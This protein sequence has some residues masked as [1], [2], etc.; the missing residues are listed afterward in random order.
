MNENNLYQSAFQEQHYSHECLAS[1]FSFFHSLQRTLKK[2]VSQ[3]CTYHSIQRLT[4][5]KDQIYGRQKPGARHVEALNNSSHYIM[6]EKGSCRSNLQTWC[7]A[8]IFHFILE[9][10][11]Q[12]EFLWIEV[13]SAHLP[14]F[15]SQVYRKYQLF[16]SL[17]V[18]LSNVYKN[19][20]TQWSSLI[21]FLSAFHSIQR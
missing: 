14:G 6:G 16:T 4:S 10:V 13:K 17:G 3:I 8:N 12:T 5:H 21:L 2:N 15:H 11:L 19:F 9:L 1:D 20:P 18:S 7:Q